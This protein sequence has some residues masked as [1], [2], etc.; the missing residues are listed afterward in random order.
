MQIM[1]YILLVI[2]YFPIMDEKTKAKVIEVKK[3][4]ASKEYD[5]ALEVCDYITIMLTSKQPAVYLFAGF[6]QE[7]LKKDAEA[8]KSY[9]FAEDLD[10][11]NIDCCKAL[12]GL[13]TR[14]KKPDQAAIYLKRL[15]Q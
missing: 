8:E 9:K 2:Y 4:I 13:Y 6:C 12:Y 14:L 3:L 5:K 11:N 1:Y 7:K 15:C 10:P